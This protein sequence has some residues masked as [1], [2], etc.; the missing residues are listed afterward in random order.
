MEGLSF[1]DSA[2]LRHRPSATSNGHNRPSNTESSSKSKMVKKG[3]AKFDAFLLQ[4]R[5]DDVLL[6]WK[7]HPIPFV[8]GSMLLFFMGVEYTLGMIP[9]TSPPYDVGFIATKWLNSIISSSPPLNTALAVANTAFVAMQTT[10]VLYTWLVEG[11]IRPTISMLFMFTCRG[12]LGYVT[13]L[14]LPEEF[15][16]SGADF[17]VGNVSFFLFYSGHVAGAVIAS[18]DMR[19]MQRW[20]LARL[21]DLLNVLQVVR[22]LGTRGH[23]T[24]DLA[25]GV[26][27]GILFDS[28]G[29]KYEESRKKHQANGIN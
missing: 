16:G 8:F 12:V 25:V 18:I 21:F 20:N 24:I 29:G 5:I 7:R 11:R 19:R 27:A 23:Y 26:G 6:V 22:L 3:F 15:L 14:P 17:P 9:S 10:Y 13:Q 4:W 28:L 1:S 2:A